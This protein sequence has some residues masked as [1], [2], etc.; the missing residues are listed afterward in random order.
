MNG[1]GARKL[2][3]WIDG[4][5]E[6]TDGLDSPALF[7]KWAAI[8]TISSVLEQ[9]VWLRSVG[10][11]LYPNLYVLL[12]G[13]PGVGK[14]RT[15]RA[16]KSYL[17]DIPDFHIAPTS[18][19]AAALIDM[20]VASKRF[21]PR[22]VPDPPLDYNSMMIAA[23]E[24]GAFVH[25]YDDEMI[26]VLSAFYDAD[27]YGHHRRGND[28]KIKIKSPQL[29]MLC[30]STPSNL[31]KFLPEGAW[32][33]GF[34]SRMLMIF[35]DERIIGDDFD[36]ERVPKGMSKD[37]AADLRHISNLTGEFKVT[38]EYQQLVNLWR[39]AGES[40]EGAPQPNHPK[41]IHYNTR[42]RAHLYKLSVIAAIDRAD[43]LL[44]TRDDFNTAM[45]WL[46]EAEIYMPEIFKAGAIG[47]DGKAM[48]E[49]YHFVMVTG[50]MVPEHKIINFARERVPAHSVMRVM[51]IMERSG[52]IQ[53]VALDRKTGMRLWRAIPKGVTDV[54]DH[55]ALLPRPPSQES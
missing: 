39:E 19:T 1:S 15:I 31:L 27:P 40:I 53:A 35:S 48:E 26:A 16:A 24:L 38:A 33:Q 29:N 54:G 6:Q 50:K 20:M 9:K 3:S 44:L 45:S 7:R 18:M 25:K 36:Y 22:P 4:F 52:M 43:T 2:A 17:L 34:T 8:S 14:T 28:I 12:V 42:R 21:V 5:V 37:L 49:I 30:G 41:L 32:D 55:A 10:G 51:D 47:A 23:D 13:H 11:V 46:S